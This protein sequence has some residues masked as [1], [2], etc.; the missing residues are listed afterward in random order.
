MAIA[1]VIPV[2]NEQGAIGP[3]V[4][5]LPAGVFDR[6][7]VVDGGSTDATV[8]EAAAFRARR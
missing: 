7:F 2:F 6:V 5:R 1:A 4:S 8:A 3:T